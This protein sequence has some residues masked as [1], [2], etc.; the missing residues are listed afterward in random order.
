MSLVF[1]V[2]LVD[3]LTLFSLSLSQSKTDSSFQQAT[4]RP[5]KAYT[6]ES[7]SQDP[8]SKPRLLCL[9]SKHAKLKNL[10]TAYH[11]STLSSNMQTIISQPLTIQSQ[12]RSQL[13]SSHG[14]PSA[15]QHFAIG[16]SQMTSWNT[17]EPPVTSR[18]DSSG[19]HYA[20]SSSRQADTE[21]YHGDKIPR[22][23]LT[24]SGTVRNTNDNTMYDIDL[25]QQARRVHPQ[26]LAPHN[27][28]RPD[29]S[30]SPTND[31]TS[32]VRRLSQRLSKRA[33]SLWGGEA[34]AMTAEDEKRLEDER[35][36][37]EEEE[38][39]LDEEEKEMLKR[40]LF[41]WSEMKH[42][43]FWIRKEWWRKLAR[44]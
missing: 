37:R 41:N 6:L 31:S 9:R 24:D 42:W 21:L 40:G 35:R 12:D 8:L 2:F 20:D 34:V 33:S 16:S 26:A 15:Q 1:K 39:R 18:T 38:R 23:T 44:L 5:L 43:R 19:P 10:Y 25:E 36:A 17:E 30:Q 4:F 29:P 7:G 28:I 11:L 32:I 14:G 3:H 27:H 22:V 13:T